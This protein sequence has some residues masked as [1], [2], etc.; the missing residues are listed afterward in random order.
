MELWNPSGGT[1]GDLDPDVE[2][3][4]PEC[5][6]SMAEFDRLEEDG[7]VFIWYA[8]TRED[9]PGQ[10]LS[11]K[12]LRKGTQEYGFW[13]GPSSSGSEVST[14]SAEFPRQPKRQTNTTD[15]DSLCGR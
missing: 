8:C 6:E 7:A 2:R 10:W 3:I 14:V 5:G 15:A 9:G 12:M 1:D 13:R 4:C 11:K